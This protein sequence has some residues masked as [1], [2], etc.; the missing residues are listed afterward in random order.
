[1]KG[2]TKMNKIWTFNVIDIYN[3]KPTI[4]AKVTT[5]KA[6]NDKQ[7]CKDLIRGFLLEN[8]E[9]EMSDSEIDVLAG[10]L[11]LFAYVKWNGTVWFE[12]NEVT[13]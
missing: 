2:L 6:L 12:L 13:F 1:M 11:A 8:E 5:D 10:N 4:W 7:K 3:P 9:Y